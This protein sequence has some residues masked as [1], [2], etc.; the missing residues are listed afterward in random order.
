MEKVKFKRHTKAERGVIIDRIYVLRKKISDVIY[1]LR[2]P[3][4]VI[5]YAVMA[6]KAAC[7]LAHKVVDNLSYPQDRYKE[8]YISP[9]KLLAKEKQMISL[10]SRLYIEED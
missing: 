9:K 1:S 3:D 8:G 4:G 10:C 6:F 7:D 5:N 2:I